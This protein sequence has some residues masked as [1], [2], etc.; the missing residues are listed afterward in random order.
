MEEERTRALKIR[1]MR[2]ISRSPV[3]L[4]IAEELLARRPS[5]SEQGRL[6]SRFGADLVRRA[7]AS[8]GGFVVW[9]NLF[10]P[11]EILLGMG[12]VPF[13]PEMASAF[14]T[15]LDITP[16]SLPL[17]GQHGCPTDLCT[18]HRNLLGLDHGDLLPPVDALIS[19]SSLCDMAGQALANIAYERDKPFIM[20]DVPEGTSETDVDYLEAQLRRVTEQLCQLAGVEMSAERLREAIEL[21]NQ[22]SDYMEEINELRKAR[23]APLRGSN[24]LNELAMITSGF[25]SEHA[26]R[27]YRTF[28]DYTRQLVAG[29]E[30]EQ[31]DQRLRLYWMHLKCYCGNDLFHLLED[32]LGVALVFEEYNTLWWERLDP[33]RPFRS[34]AR[35]VLQHFNLGPI[36]R[37]AEQAIRRVQEY[38]ADGV[39]HFGH[40]GCRQSTGALPVLRDRL[41]DEGIPFLQIDGDIIDGANLQWGQMKTRV[42]GFVEMLEG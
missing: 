27:Y 30:T 12:L 42:E 33:E 37:R 2:A 40:W 5:F 32:E 9:S 29:G 38:D 26:V 35:K 19:T 1:L 41:R 11:S 7:Y 34:L 18:V 14:A 17:A 22:A 21:S 6:A 28:R 25:G 13:Y 23:P 36:E 20:V 15:V 4:R 3:A 24:M 8:E 39:V 31:P 10:F 16:W